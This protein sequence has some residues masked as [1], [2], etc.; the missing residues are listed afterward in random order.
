MTIARAALC[1]LALIAVAGCSESA[2][3][4]R[5]KP[6]AGKPA[7]ATPS[8]ATS[9]PAVPRFEFTREFAIGGEG[10]WDYVTCDRD[11]RR[12]YVP[13]SDRVMILN[14]VTGDVIATIPGTPGVH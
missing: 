2:G 9:A 7:V 1:A 4:S 5:T 14:A 6:A 12:L 8:V 13:R 3:P 10:R 11:A